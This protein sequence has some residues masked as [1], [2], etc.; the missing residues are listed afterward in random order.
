ALR[1][2]LGQRD[3]ILQEPASLCPV[4]SED[5]TGATTECVFGDNGWLAREVDMSWFGN[6]QF[7][8]TT[9][10]IRRRTARGVLPRFFC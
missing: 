9:A 4:M 8:M 2:F 10:S 3:V 7:E 1:I 5:F 6:G